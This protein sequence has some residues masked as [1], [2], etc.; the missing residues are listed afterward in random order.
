MT[1]CSGDYDQ[2]V[3]SSVQIHSGHAYGVSNSSPYELAW[4]SLFMRA[5]MNYDKNPMETCANMLDW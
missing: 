1:C 2:G 5:H 4:D 3:I